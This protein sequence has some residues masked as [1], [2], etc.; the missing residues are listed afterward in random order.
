MSL[1][2]HW[3]D[4]NGG[5][6]I[7][8][9]VVT[10]Y[11]QDHSGKVTQHPI[12]AGGNVTDHFVKNNSKYKI[13]AV[14]TGVDISTGTYL[15][16]D[17]Q[18]NSPYNSY[19]LKSPVSV[20]STDSSVLK[21]FIPDSVGQFL[22]DTTPDVEVDFGQTDLLE[23]IKDTLISLMS[24]E[25]LDPTTGRY[26]PNIQLI[27]LYEYDGYTLTRVINRL[28]LTSVTFRETPDTGYA[29]YCDFS[30]EQVTFVNLKQTELPSDVQSS[31]KK[32]A[33]SKSSKGKQDSKVQ[34]AGSGDNPP[35]DSDIDPLRQAR[36]N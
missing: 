30:L 6:F 7:Y 5:G 11:S 26:N 9:N 24:G 17:L 18:G 14:I 1:A 13:G 29:L 34:D 15:I 19:T 8:M 12:D 10:S 35:K 22:S 16:Q 23:Q 2:I 25:I 32:K 21:K 31:L 36:E 4:E 3:D 28:V 20:N 33:S 27:D